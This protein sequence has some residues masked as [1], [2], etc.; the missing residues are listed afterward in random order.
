MRFEWDA[1]KNRRNHAKHKVGFETARLVFD[2]PW[3]LSLPERMVEAEERWHT[4]GVVGEVVVLLVAHTYREEQA[5]AV[6]RIISARK[7]IPR[8][9][10]AFEEGRK[11]QD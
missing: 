2:D 10:R 4:I 3:A 8:E 5:E 11:A 7:A 6:I 9:R 1:E